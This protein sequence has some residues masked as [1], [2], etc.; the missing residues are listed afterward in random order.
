MVFTLPKCLLLND[1]NSSMAAP[2]TEAPETSIKKAPAASDSAEKQTSENNAGVHSLKKEDWKNTE[3]KKREEMTALD[4][5]LKNSG[6]LPNTTIDATSNRP[7]DVTDAAA[8][9]E[10]AKVNDATQQKLIQTIANDKSTAIEKLK[11]VEE[12]AKQG[13]TS[14]SFNDVNGH[15]RNLRIEIEPAGSRKMV[16]LY[17]T[18]NSG[19]DRILVRG[20]SNGDGTFAREKDARGHDVSY[21]GSWWETHM[22]GQSKL[23]QAAEN[24]TDEYWDA[25]GEDVQGRLRQ[26]MSNPTVW[27]EW[28]KSNDPTQPLPSIDQMNIQ[29]P[30]ALN[31][32]FDNVSRDKSGRSKR[33]EMLP[34]GVLYFRSGMQVD[35]DGSPRARQIDPCGQSQTSLRHP[36][37]APVNAERVPYIVLPGG[38]YKHLGIKLGDIAAVRYQGKVQFAVFADVGPSYKIGEGSMALADALGIN[39]SPT[40]GGTHRPDVEYLVFRGSGDR[41]PGRPVETQ[42]KGVALLNQYSRRRQQMA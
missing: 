7:R 19:K 26:M 5:S 22:N 27:S 24:E 41:T 20:V 2:T 11:A 32:L 1:G 35:A 37:G 28:Q 31:A 30:R 6:V 15:T 12:L 40:R 17:A 3:E 39:P 16:H 34:G 21:Y 14:F 13:T 29:D 9:I 38:S 33:M 4:A 8:K 18:D 42:Q 10:T 36:N 23:G 25:R